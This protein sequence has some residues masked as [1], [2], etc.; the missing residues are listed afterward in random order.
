MERIQRREEQQIIKGT[1]LLQMMMIGNQ[2]A[3]IQFKDWY[4][5]GHANSVPHIHCYGKGFHL[6][7]SNGRR[8]NLVQKNVKY[9]H[10]THDAYEWIR[11]ECAEIHREPLLAALRELFR[12][13][14]AGANPDKDY[15]PFTEV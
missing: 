14:Y 1:G 6:K 9:P 4:A 15:K 2:T 10:A 5:Y 13:T 12:E 11:N 3:I 8:Y 7:D